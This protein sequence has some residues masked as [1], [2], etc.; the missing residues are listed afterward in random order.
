M[1][2]TAINPANYWKYFR[3]TLRVLSN[4]YGQKQKDR[5]LELLDMVE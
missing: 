5:V 1:A 3:K 4:M 2:D